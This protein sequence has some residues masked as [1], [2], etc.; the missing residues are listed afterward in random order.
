[1]KSDL[2]KDMEMLWCTKYY[3]KLDCSEADLKNTVLEKR[4]RHFAD[5]FKSGNL[6]TK[7]NSS[8]SF[9]DAILL[10]QKTLPFT[11]RPLLGM[12]RP[13]RLTKNRPQFKQP[14]GH[15]IHSS[16]FYLISMLSHNYF[17][18]KSGRRC[19]WPFWISRR[20]ILS[21]RGLTSLILRPKL[22]NLSE[23]FLQYYETWFPFL[24][25]IRI[26][27]N[28]Q[29]HL[30]WFL[31]WIGPKIQTRKKPGKIQKVQKH[32]RPDLFLK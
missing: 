6:A 14:K 11:T 4:F 2:K 18:N 16:F 3:S 12:K 26:R 9:L 27:P 20:K 8:K 10:C 28:R 7:I 15:I 29:Q 5:F 25:N 21:A 19:F 13:Q 1:M 17:K 23:I 32:W 30:F 31:K 22:R 24:E